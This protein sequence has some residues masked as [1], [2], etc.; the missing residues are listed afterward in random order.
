VVQ[1]GVQLLTGLLLT[2]PFQQRFS[3]L[4]DF[5][6]TL[7]LVTVALSVAATA[8]LVAPVA[9]HRAL[10]RLHARRTLVALGQRLAVAGLT[11]LALAV[12]GVVLL[13]FD[14]VAGPT[15]GII[16]AAVVLVVFVAFW[17]VLPLRERRRARREMG[18]H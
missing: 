6:R 5:Q 17:G 15:T 8:L 14:T 18:S 1:T 11:M 13:I 7:Y 4:S 3:T 10:F 9:A 16:A 12:T 2:V